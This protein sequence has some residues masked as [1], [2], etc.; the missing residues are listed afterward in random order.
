MSESTTENLP[1]RQ[2]FSPDEL[3]A[4]DSWQDAQRLLLESGV[5]LRDA[6]TEIGDGFVMLDDKSELVNKPMLILAWIFAPGDFGENYCI[7]RVVTGDGSKYVVTDGSTGLAAQIRE[8]EARTGAT[9][10]LL[11]QRGLR[12]SE[13]DTEINGEMVHGTTF[14]LNV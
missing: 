13:Y 1:A 9:G 14:Y 3:R 7:M 12:K 5:E 11:V 8:Y 2:T 10:G 6:S 4:I